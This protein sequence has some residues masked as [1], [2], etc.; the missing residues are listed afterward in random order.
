MARI[1]INR[2]I[3][4]QLNGITF[5]K[6]NVNLNEFP[7]FLILG[8]QRTGTNWLYENLKLHPRVFLTTPK[9][10][11]FF[12]LV[13]KPEHHLYSSSDLAWYLEFYHES[14]K[15]F[16]KKNLEMLKR[17]GKFYYPQV[18]GEATASYAA[19]SKELIDNIVILNPDIKAI[20]MVRNPLIRIW[21][22]AKKNLLNSNFL[23]NYQQKSLEE[24]AEDEFETFFRREAKIVDYNRIIE[25]WSSALK[26]GNLFIGF[27]DDIIDSPTTLL[28][29]VFDF[30]EI[31]SKDDYITNLVKKKIQSTDTSEKRELPE[32]Y[33]IILE[34]IFKD[35]ILT[36]E[37]KFGRQLLR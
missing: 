17:Y 5:S 11:F 31:D 20:L 6:E 22:H 12:N 8:P 32:K 26:E 10:L 14:F 3:L 4:T 34:E 16:L 36:L 35:E 27:F 23:N 37:E 2:E 21:S 24:V 25:N 29:K 19:M 7:D 1:K 15:N 18:R 13:Q 30:L 9:E 33:K 28:L